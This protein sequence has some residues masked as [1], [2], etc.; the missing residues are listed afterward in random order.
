MDNSQSIDIIIPVFNG[1]A[2]I[3]DTIRRL[4]ALPVTDKWQVLILVVDDGSTDST[5]TFL[6]KVKSPRLKILRLLENKGRAAAR[7]FGAINSRANYLLFLDSDCL[8]GGQDYLMEVIANLQNGASLIFGPIG[9]TG[10]G[11]W[12]WYLADVEKTRQ[13]NAENRQWLNAITSANLLVDHEL[14]NRAGGFKPEYKYYGFEDR[15][16][17]IRLLAQKPD[18]FFSPAMRVLH[19]SGNTVNIYCR[20]M[21]IAARYSAPLF[22]RD[23]FEHYQ[24]MVYGNFDPAVNSKLWLKAV[25]KLSIIIKWPFIYIANILVKS[26]LFPYPITKTAL[27]AASAIS[28]IHG[29]RKRSNVPCH[30]SNYE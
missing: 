19:H 3:A 7:H 25:G 18:I 24:K 28:Y 2:T 8:P 15:D 26:K 5:L 23:H 12:Q 13:E 4:L 11:F 14:Y 1:S 17:I 16:L 10:S 9:T 29:A 22:Y 27:Q 6:K 30:S 21:E 20:K